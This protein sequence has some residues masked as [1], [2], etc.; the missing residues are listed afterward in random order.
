MVVVVVLVYV[1]SLTYI[2]E[3]VV[4]EVVVVVVV[5]AV[6][7]V[8]R[9]CISRACLVA[10]VCYHSEHLSQCVQQCNNQAAEA[11][12]PERRRHR[13][14]ERSSHRSLAMRLKPPTG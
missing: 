4:L 14:E 6:L 7:V 2:S 11:N 13:S 5:V 10:D 9:S 3:V 8:G 12:G 1:K